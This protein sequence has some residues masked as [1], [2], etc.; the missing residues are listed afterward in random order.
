[1]TSLI[2]E[3]IRRDAQKRYAEKE[4]EQKILQY[5]IKRMSRHNVG[6]FQTT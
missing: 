1:M 4:Q 5:K 3:Q 6:D 2:V